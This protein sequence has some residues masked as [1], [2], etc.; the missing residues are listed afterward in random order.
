MC[1]QLDSPAIISREDAGAAGLKRYFTGEL[2]GRGHVC[3]RLVSTRVCVECSNS[4]NTA[5]RAANPDKSRNSTAAW[6][7]A[8]PDKEKAR[9]AAWQ[10][11]NPDKKKASNDAW[12]AANPDKVKTSMRIRI[13]RRRACKRG[14]PGHHTAAET[15]SLLEAQGFTCAASHCNADLREVPKHLDHITP[16]SRPELNPTNSIENL[17]WL[18]H[19]CNHSKGAK[20][21]KEW[22][23]VKDDSSLL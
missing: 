8:H 16:L 19:R 4:S 18:C 5:W 22:E 9:V 6:R 2:C 10:A 20:T 7:A 13:T 1:G 11:A 3:E 21:M 23:G 12:R 14:V 15:T 17:Q